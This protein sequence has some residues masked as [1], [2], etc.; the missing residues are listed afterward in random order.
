MV[1]LTKAYPRGR[2]HRSPNQVRSTFSVRAARSV[3]DVDV[4]G[5]YASILEKFRKCDRNEFPCAYSKIAHLC[6][7]ECSR[8]P[9]IANKLQEADLLERIRVGQ[10][11]TG[12]S[13]PN[14]K[15]VKQRITFWRLKHIEQ[16]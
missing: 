1:R 5:C 13:Y 4:N 11:E 10:I 15:P 16:G 8:G 6:G 7:E 12:D 14:G 3:L 9:V 2:T